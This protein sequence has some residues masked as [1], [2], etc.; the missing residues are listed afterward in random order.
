MYAL[1]GRTV[2][3]DQ[4]GRY[5]KSKQRLEA[6]VARERAF[7]LL[8]G[9][10]K[11]D[12][13]L[14]RGG[15]ISDKKEVRGLALRAVENLEDAKERERLAIWALDSQHEDIQVAMLELITRYT[16]DKERMAPIIRRKL[17]SANEEIV[18]GAL[19]TA[20]YFLGKEELLAI[21]LGYV[22]SSSAAIQIV[23]L[24]LIR[25]YAE[26]N[27]A[28]DIFNEKAQ[29][30]NDSKVL[31]YLILLID[32]EILSDESKR[33]VVRKGLESSDKDLILAA[34]RT[35][36]S[37]WLLNKMFNLKV[38]CEELESDD[39]I[40][41]RDV[42]KFLE[43]HCK[44]KYLEDGL[45]WKGV[46]EKLQSDDKDAMLAA[47]NELN[48]WAM[49]S[50]YYDPGI[51]RKM[52]E[53]EDEYLMMA[54]LKKMH[55]LGSWP[56]EAILRNIKKGSIFFNHDLSGWL[57]IFPEKILLPV[58]IALLETQD[59]DVEMVV[60]DSIYREDF[61]EGVKLN[62][63][64]GLIHHGDDK[65]RVNAL[66]HIDLVPQSSWSGIILSAI[67]VSQ[68]REVQSAA[69]ALMA[70]LPETKR[71]E[72]LLEIKRVCPQD[73]FPIEFAEIWSQEPM[74]RIK[75]ILG[76][77]G[78]WNKGILLKAVELEIGSVPEELRKK[79]IQD[80]CQAAHEHNK[81]LYR[82]H[83]TRTDARKDFKK[84]GSELTTLGKE[85]TDEVIIR[86]ISTT[87]FSYWQRAYENWEIWKNLG[88]D[89]VPIEPILSFNISR[90]DKS[91][92]NVV[93]GVLGMTLD[94]Y[95]RIC[96]DSH[97]KELLET[98]DLVVKGLNQLK[99]Q[100]GHAHRSNFCIY[101]EE[102]EDGQVNL[103]EV[104]K[105]YLIDFDMAEKGKTIAR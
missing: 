99:I 35:I 14:I 104:P 101:F 83:D 69:V 86:H 91:K 102:D 105:L 81:V 18:L 64:T 92:I 59:I 65:V 60:W 74:I 49:S 15:L 12:E 19:K 43:K 34:F 30:S 52:A 75:T 21:S 46:K 93:A 31:A 4:V 95:T 3:E 89:Y 97:K 67:K 66:A 73:T 38:V 53:S 51:I 55:K 57:K 94:E 88:F 2:S 41:K 48:N 62:V 103:E 82:N 5:I 76:N 8:D 28:R 77:I 98:V 87:A 96:P 17:E 29:N 36:D 54:A 24:S 25:D 45:D 39:P 71:G 27:R 58:I 13:D 20:R 23:A 44:K 72:M 40:I 100:H 1:P 37:E 68:S 63:L 50:D 10:Y 33:K 7:A 79:A 11:L 90:K 16:Q 80:Y 47:L 61:D 22:E 26:K 56:L 6:Y 32:S 70:N 78:Q 84:N 9:N 85:F 42:L